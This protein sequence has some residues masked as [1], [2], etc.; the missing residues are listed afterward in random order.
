MVIGLGILCIVYCELCLRYMVTEKLCSAIVF[1]F[2]VRV[3]V[4][5]EECVRQRSECI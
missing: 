4:S 1:I 5:V 3:G 2:W